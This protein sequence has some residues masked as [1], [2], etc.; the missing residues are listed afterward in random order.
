[1]SD[2]SPSPNPYVFV[3]GCPRS[4]T[5]LLQRVLDAHPRLAI[6]N[7]TGF[8]PQFF[9]QRIGLTH[10]GLVTPELIPSLL[11]YR[12]FPKLKI[13]REKLL[14]ISDFGEPVSFASFMSS[15]YDLY[16]KR[17]GKRL[18]GD[19]TPGYVRS[20]PT[21]HALW[22]EAKFVHLIRDGRDV[23]LSSLQWKKA[24]GTTAAERGARRAGSGLRAR[25]ARLVRLCRDVTLSALPHKTDGLAKAVRLGNQL[26]T[27]NADPLSRQA[28]YW[29]RHVR[30]GREDGQA[31]GPR[32]YYELRYELLVTQPAEQLAALFTFLELAY[33][34]AVLSFAD[35]RTKVEPGLDAKKAWLPIT[36]G[37]RDW[38]SQMSCQDVERFEALSGDLIDELGYPR[39]VR[40]PSAESL[41]DAAKILALETETVRA[42]GNRL[43]TQW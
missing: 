28:L 24:D 16:G 31:L 19:K 6:I 42:Q 27:E 40:H 32:R 37:L 25:L 38:R 5:T 41:R 39:V 8:I 9:E 23:A 14:A 34:D 7:E 22:P 3:V 30:L 21:L 17:R 4:G 29:K 12:R 1:M 2:S 20:I 18:V 26:P 35:N 11:Q 33:D 36:P 13:N 15:V 10:D 43:P